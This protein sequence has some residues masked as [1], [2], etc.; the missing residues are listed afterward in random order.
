M[1]HPLSRLSLAVALS[2]APALA[3]DRPAPLLAQVPYDEGRN[4]GIGGTVGVASGAGVSYQEILPSAFGFRGTL[5]GWKLGGSSFIDLG[6]SGLR[7]LSDDGSRRI[8]LIGGMSYWRWADEDIEE[9]VDDQGNVVAEREVDDVDNSWSVG[10]GAGVEL[11]WTTRT[12]IAFEGLFTY[13][14]KSEDFLPLPQV[15]IH[16]QF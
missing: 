1:R 6:V 4:Q 10:V 8:Y 7:V 13:W 12:V 9:I 3:A 14:G 5:F 16:Y 11:P 15:S 2:A